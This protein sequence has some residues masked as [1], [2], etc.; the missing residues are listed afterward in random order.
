MKTS[1]RAKTKNQSVEDGSLSPLTRLVTHSLLA[2][3]LP[4]CDDNFHR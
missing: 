4:L 3:P 2:S 1:K